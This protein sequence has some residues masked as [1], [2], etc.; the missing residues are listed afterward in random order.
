MTNAKHVFTKS[1]LLLL[2][3]ILLFQACGEEPEHITEVDF[4][5]VEFAHFVEREFPFIT[6]SMM[7]RHEEEWFIENNIAARCIAL[8]LGEESYACFDTDMLRWAAAWTGDFVPMEGVSHRSYPDYLGRND[9]MVELPG[10][11]KLVTG[12]YPGWNAGE[13][14]F[15]DP[16]QPA[17]HPDEPSW[18]AMPQEMGRWNGIYVTDEG[19]VLSYSIGQTEILEYPGSIESDGET[20]FTRT[21]RIEAPQEPLSLKSGEF[22]D[23]T[24]VES[25]ENRLTITHQ[26]ENDQ[27]VFALTGT[28]ENAELNLIDERYAVVQIPASGETVEFTLLTSRG[29]NGTA[30]RVNQAGESDF[31]LP[32]YNEGG[33]NLWP[34]D[35]YTRGK[36]APDTSAYVV[37]EFTLPIPN[38]WNRNVRVVDIDFFDDGR[39][40]IV[41]FEGD[42]WIVDG[43]S[44]DLQS[45]K[46]NRFASG[47]YETQSIEIVDGEIYTYGKDGIVRLHDLNGNGSADYYENFSNLMAQSIETREWASDFVAKPG[48]GFYVAKGAALDMGPRALTAPVERGIRAGSQH[49]GVI[50][51]ISE[52]GRNANVIAS[53]FRGPYLGIHPETGFLTA[54]DQEGHHVPSTPILTIN[55]TDFFGVNATAHRDEIPEITPP[56]LWIPHNVD[57][58]GIS[59]TWIT[60]DQMGPL[61]GDLVHMSYGRPGLFRVLI[62]S[63]DSGA[64]GGVT[65]IPGHYPVPTM[66]GRVHPSDGQLYVGGFT[67]W[68]TNSDGMTGL[69]R[70]RYTGQPSY[71]P[72]SFS[73][74]EE[75][76]FL[77]FDQE[78]DEEAVADISGYRAERW[79]YLRTEQYG[80][81]HYQLDGSPGQELLPVFS[82]HL[83]DDRK[84]IFLAIPTIEVAEQMQLTYRLKASDGHE[85]EDDFWFSVHH[86]EPADFESKGF[87]GIEKDELFTDA[88]AWEALDDS[89][90]P[91]T[92]ERGKVLFERS[93][94]MG[95]HTVDGSTG[96]GVG[97]TMKG[98]IGKEREFQDG[99]STVADVEYI[100][101]TILHPNE[102]ILEGYDEGMPSFLGILSD[103]EIDSIVLYIQSLDE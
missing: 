67:L 7:M 90:E 88:S 19:P 70:L 94:C 37:D 41:T 82:A 24:E 16:R 91:V 20:V 83:S 40:A 74:R 33:S 14:L 10:T 34:D 95:C 25:I 63:T 49:S 17:P 98:L 96:T 39:A 9:V 3:I 93:G 13:P 5:N 26:N 78:L 23:I 22:S 75:G 42:V 18:G 54:S 55:E 97:P 64:Q 66:K 2:S 102:Q 38:P 86:V 11:P 60:S 45:V 62:D 99:T 58:S 73:V 100:R 21:F 44:R 76:I 50:L 77:R 101:Q 81:G 43:I 15:D 47:L 53:G 36:T 28:T 92:A 30:D 52:D 32:N 103:D 48:G 29:N 1:G 80:S 4:D 57:R 6:T 46:W 31:T 85:F 69:L 59:Q 79:N 12:Q 56:L 61:S 27:T 72:E 84:G 51:E 68:G 65:V 89:G 71:I 35:V 87:S 8:I